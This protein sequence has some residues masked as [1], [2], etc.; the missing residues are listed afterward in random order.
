M[1]TPLVV[2]FEDVAA[3][4]GPLVGGKAASLGELLR[5]GAR[6]PEGLAV[7]TAASAR[8]LALPAL[9]EA[10]KEALERARAG[11]LDEGRLAALRQR[12]AATPLPDDVRQA[13]LEARRK[14]WADGVALAVRSSG[15]KEDLAGASFAGQYETVL[16]VVGDDALEAALKRCLAS[17]WT[18]RVLGYAAERGGGL[19]GLAMGVAVQRLVAAEVAGVMFTVH[20]LTGRE[21]ETLVEAAFGLGEALVSGRTNADQFVVRPTDG[22]VLERKLADK[23]VRIEALPGGGTREVPLEGEARS[24]P[25]LDDAQ[26]AELARAG[27]D[28]QVHYGRPMDVEFALQGGQLW[29]LQARPITKLS[30]A[31]DAGEWTT[32]D[33][34]DGGV[35]SDVCAPFMWS[36]YRMC[37]EHSMPRYLKGI[38]LLDARD[39]RRWMGY[40]FARPYWN[41]GGIKEVL[42][43]VPG[44]VERNFDADL[45]IAPSYEG[46]GRQTPVTFRGVLGALPVLFALKRSYKQVLEVDRRFCAELDRKKA[47]F[48]KNDAELAALPFADFLASYQSLLRG[49]Y[50]ETETQ[51]FTTIYNTSNS[52]LDFKVHFE[53]AKKAAGEL[54]YLALV[55]GLQD[56]SHMRPLADLQAL[57]GRVVARGGGPTDEEVGGFA[58]RWRHHGRKELDIR[59]PR[60]HE[61]LGFV[62]QT[63]GEGVASFDAA[64]DPTAAAKAQHEAYLRERKKAERALRFR[65]YARSGFSRMLDLVRRY[66]WWREEMRDKSSY[67]YYLVRRWSLE[68]ARRLCMEGKLEAADDLWYLEMDDVLRLLEG[69]LAVGDA[70]RKIASGRR[71]VQAFRNFKNPN[72]IGSQYR[73]GARAAVAG[74]NVLVGTGCS[75]GRVE[76]RARVVS[77]LEDVHRVEKGDIL[78]TPFTDPGWTPVFARIGGV[79]TETGGVLAHAAVIS[80]EYGLPAVLAVPGATERIPDGARVVVD[81]GAGTVELVKP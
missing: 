33:F 43:S 73:H 19:D 20:P 48:E 5:A 81:G 65:P 56:L 76:G 7:T 28:I 47:P 68:A 10:A 59:V 42:A 38:K 67:A 29:I 14:L 72:E 11:E 54:D 39:D 30:F 1:T 12:L 50:F 34:K 35:S 69:K 27:A 25:T 31:A 18:P 57:C 15:T 24:A 75:P 61:D 71:T 63:I 21:G 32:A 78:V 49:L 17:L 60:W 37:V 74:G 26:L 4:S 53:R 2:T 79:V 40:F 16:G 58:E 62:R 13:L 51:Y 23:S 9:S 8:F 45:G 70:W 22:H 6:V 55:G 41:L 46:L 3:D 77:R 64:H 52:K 36:L 44:F 80:R 66:A